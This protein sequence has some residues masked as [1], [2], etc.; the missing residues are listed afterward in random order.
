[1]LLEPLSG[2]PKTYVLYGAPGLRPVALLPSAPVRGL[3]TTTGGRVFAFTSTTLYEVFSGWS[4]LARGTIPTGTNPISASDNGLHLVFSVEGQGRLYDLATDT[5]T[6]LPTTGPQSWGQFGY[7]DGYLLVHEPGTR[8]FWY[9]ALLDATTW[10]AL[11]F[12]AAEAR[13]D[14]ITALIIDHR[15]VVVFGTQSIEVWN[16]TGDSLSPFARMQAAAL[17]QGCEAPWSVA[18]LDSSFFWLG[19]SPRGQGPVFAMEGYQPQRVS[20]WALEAAMRTMPT[21]ADARAFTLRQGGHAFYGL[22]FPA[23]NQTWL[24]DRGTG[25]WTE[26]ASL[27]DDGSLSAYPCAVTTLAF[28]EHLFGSRTTGDLF[29][30]DSA[31]HRYGLQPRLCRRVTPHLRKE[32]D[33]VRYTKFGL[34]LD[35]GRGLDGA[36]VPGADPQVM[37]RVSTD[38]GH[39]WGYGRWRSAGKLG[40]YPQQVSWYQLGQ[41]RMMTF[42]VSCSDPVP[43]AWIGATVEVS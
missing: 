31:Y 8:R 19:G 24:F 4:F 2:D 17:E 25:A 6:A 39:T 35:A 41:A 7:L 13:P 21:L 36:A 11:S 33:R 15:Q 22:T 27:E 42:E 34:L 38:A 10:P 30:S 18:A 9:S 40:A 28:G 43:V 3:Y 5:L 12:Y 37:L 29:V 32:Q 1:M 23:G 20:S 16:S 14:P 26:L